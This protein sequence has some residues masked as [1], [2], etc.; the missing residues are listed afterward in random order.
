MKNVNHH[1]QRSSLYRVERNTPPA[2]T[3]RDPNDPDHASA[4]AF[5]GPGPDGPGGLAYDILLGTLSESAQGICS[6]LR[7]R[8]NAP[9]KRLQREMASVIEF[10]LLS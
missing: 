8:P 5:Q 1:F 4:P 10:P 9:D 7:V 6:A 2:L 3:T